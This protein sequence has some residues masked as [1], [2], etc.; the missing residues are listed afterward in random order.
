[1]FTQLE[2][3]EFIIAGMVLCSR[4]APAVSIDLICS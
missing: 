1:M 4:S 2:R 3:Y